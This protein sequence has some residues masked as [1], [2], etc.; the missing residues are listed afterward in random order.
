MLINTNIFL[1]NAIK[2]FGND[3]CGKISHNASRVHGIGVGWYLKSV[4]M[5]AVKHNAQVHHRLLSALLSTGS[6]SSRYAFWVIID[7]LMFMV[8]VLDRLLL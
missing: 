6:I 7:V 8:V 5:I 2:K 1:I 4:T 3:F